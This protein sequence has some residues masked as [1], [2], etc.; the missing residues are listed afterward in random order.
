M[1]TR[2]QLATLR[3]AISSTPLQTHLFP[4]QCACGNHISASGQCDACKKGRLDLQRRAVDNQ[5]EPSEVSSVVH[6][7]L[8]S[9]G[10]PLDPT[11]RAFMEPRFGHDFS[12]VR[13]HANAKA[14]DSARA[15]N[16]LA[17][18]VGP[19]V[20]FAA[21]QYAPDTIGG[22]QV[23][24]HELTHTIQQSQGRTGG[25]LF[26]SSAQIS[27]PRDTH[28][29][30]AETQAARVAVGQGITPISRMSGGARLQRQADVKEAP[31][32]TPPSPSTSDC[33]PAQITMLASHLASAR[34]WVD[35]AERKIADYAYAFASTRH[36]AEPRDPAA[37]KVVRS[38]LQDNFHTIEPGYVRLIAEN[39]ADLRTELN[40]SFTYECEDEGCKD[41][42]YVRGAFAFI[43]RHGNI[44][45]CPP[46][47]QCTDYLDRVKT[48]IH[49]RAHQH[50]GAGGDTY[51]D[52]A[53][54]AK[55][56]P[57]DAV[58]NADCYALTARQIYHGGTH[59]P[60]P[61]KC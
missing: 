5:S 8:R 45:V 55:L 14:A 47:F 34:I 7:V 15:V 18:T 39:F 61:R 27:D 6:D 41:V 33:D 21:G 60:G 22:R 26:D 19:D 37:A 12:K 35:D 3:P 16:A 31:A 2:L 9:P 56:S 43:R 42:A 49:E 53:A 20:V 17:Y 40:K 52:E 28:E 54:Y 24:A 48:L 32:K 13:V 58:E 51:E 4:R 1:S 57:D 36:E 46:W 29:K 25:A 11:I 38:A 50:P 59:G 44:H 30:E 10:Q 23:L